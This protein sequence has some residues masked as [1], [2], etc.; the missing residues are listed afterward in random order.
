MDAVQRLIEIA[1]RYSKH[2]IGHMQKED[3]L[4]F[5][6]AEDLLDEDAKIALMQNLARRNTESNG[7]LSRK[8]ERLAAELENAWAV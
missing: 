4:L 1:D 5:R 2:L 7:E 6:M 3:T 8:Y